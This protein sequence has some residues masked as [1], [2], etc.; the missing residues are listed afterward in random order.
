M[1][2][3]KDDKLVLIWR[4][5]EGKTYK[6]G[7]LKRSKNRFYFKYFNDIVSNIDEDEDFEALPMLPKINVEYFS[8][9]LF[10]S[11]VNMIPERKLKRDYDERSDFE[12][13]K[14]SLKSLIHKEFYFI[15]EDENN[16]VV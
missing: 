15:D 3:K 5:D 6:I 2:K 11:F 7:R 14:S 8:E 10:R 12:I 4:N 16:E 13:L 1:R 9:E